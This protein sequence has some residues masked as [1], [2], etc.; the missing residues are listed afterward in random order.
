MLV[1]LTLDYLIDVEVDEV[2][3]YSCTTVDDG[4]NLTY[5]TRTTPRLPFC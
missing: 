4:N 5:S 2:H 3:V 1:K